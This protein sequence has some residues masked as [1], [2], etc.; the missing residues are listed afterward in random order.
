MEAD[1]WPL[2]T[3]ATLIPLTS[4]AVAKLLGDCIIDLV[5][6][7]RQGDRTAESISTIETERFCLLCSLVLCPSQPSNNH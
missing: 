6:A 3:A 2:S 4:T 7:R 5:A 1:G